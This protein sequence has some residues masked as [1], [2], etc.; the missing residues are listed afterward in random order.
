MVTV[1]RINSSEF[2]TTTER[3]KNSRLDC[4]KIELNFGVSPDNWKKSLEMLINSWSIK[5]V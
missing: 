5:D 4:N 1:H 3:P 2:S